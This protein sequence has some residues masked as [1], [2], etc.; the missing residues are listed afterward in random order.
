MNITKEDTGK[1]TATIK[2]EIEE[3]DYLDAVK[4]NTERLP[5]ESKH[6]R[7]QAW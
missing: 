3:N 7:F 2:V 1:L 6:A 4:K 5:K